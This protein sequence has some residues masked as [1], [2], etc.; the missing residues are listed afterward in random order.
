MEVFQYLGAVLGVMGMG[1]LSLFP[2]YI[3]I[4]LTITAVSCVSMG[5]YGFVTNQYG[6]ATAQTIYLILNV[7][8]IY[9]WRKVNVKS[10]S[11]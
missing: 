9:S 1:I 5:F 10:D 7:V 3:L 8:G 6:I 2:K 11:N 4:G